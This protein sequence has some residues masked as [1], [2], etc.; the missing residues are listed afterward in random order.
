MYRCISPPTSNEIV[1]EVE[2]LAPQLPL[3]SFYGTNYVR[4]LFNLHWLSE[5]VKVWNKVGAVTTPNL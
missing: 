5:M 2:A 3:F 4:T 1:P